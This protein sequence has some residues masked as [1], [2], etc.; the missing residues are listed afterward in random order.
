MIKEG[1]EPPTFVD[2]ERIKIFLK[3]LK[4]FYN[5]TMR[6]SGS[7]YVTSNMY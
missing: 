1:L 4:L 3:F 6:L 7:L 5:A 2:W